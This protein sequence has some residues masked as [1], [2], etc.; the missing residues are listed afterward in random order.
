MPLIV[1]LLSYAPAVIVPRLLALAQITLLARLVP[2]NDLGRFLL[3]ITIGDAIDLFCSNWVRIA[4]A[5]FASGQPER[6]GEE[7]TRS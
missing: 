4:L 1:S 7:T 2:A 5:R 3:V 6:L